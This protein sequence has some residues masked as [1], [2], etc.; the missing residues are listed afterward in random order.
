MGGKAVGGGG[1]G[2]QNQEEKG[3]FLNSF[4]SMGRGYP[5]GT[6]PK[7]HKRTRIGIKEKRLLEAEIFRGKDSHQENN[8]NKG[9][10][11]K[12]EKKK[13]RKGCRT[14]KKEGME[15]GMLAPGRE[16]GGHWVQ[17]TGRPINGGRRGKKR[18]Q[19]APGKGKKPPQP[20]KSRME[21][22]LKGTTLFRRIHVK[23]I[24]IK[25]EKKRGGRHGHGGGTKKV[26][27]CR[28]GFGGKRH[29]DRGKAKIRG[30]SGKPDPGQ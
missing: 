3:R 22:S 23:S 10:M 6:R 5:F 15:I 1:R 17:P 28:V 7:F 12:G 24:R 9:K 4:P 20:K 16:G 18:R 19:G 2:G 14:T 27:V 21:N 29:G 26:K 8:N 13:D 30:K 25:N 11:E